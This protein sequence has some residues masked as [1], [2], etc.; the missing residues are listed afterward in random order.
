MATHI[1]ALFNDQNH[2]Q[3]ALR[4]LNERGLA[5]SR[6]SVI[7]ADKSGAAQEQ[8]VDSEGNL[9]AEGASKG[10]KSGLVVGG[11]AGAAIGVA[12]FGLGFVPLLGFLVAGPVAGLLTGAA[13]GAA[14][15]T[16]LGGLVGLG[17]PEH[18][19]ESYSESVRRGGY[20]VIADVDDANVDAYERILHDAGAVDVNESAGP[21]TSRPVTTGAATS[22]ATAPTGAATAASLA[23]QA[24]PVAPP[25][26]AP[27]MQPDTARTQTTETTQPAQTTATTTE[28]AEGGKIAIVEE[29]LQV[30]KREV[31]SGGVRVRRF[32]TEKEA[33]ADVQL[34]EEHVNVERHAVSRPADAA[35][36]KEGTIEVRTTAE[37]PVVAKEARVVEE[38]T[39]GKTA[40]TR[41]EHVSDTVRRSDVEIQQLEAEHRAH[42]EGNFAGKDYATYQPAY[43][44]GSRIAADSRYTGREYGTFESDLRA[45]Y[46][47]NNPTSKFD[48]AKAA[49]R[50]GYDAA[51]R[52]AQS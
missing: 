35:D 50:A 19:V 48:E 14:T 25:T 18:D 32:V 2:A 15:G 45:D 27:A 9:A 49:I 7:A 21:N 10:L 8:H 5:G 37:V 44:Y 1:V 33:T 24:R 13:A 6:I 29:E 41:T 17:I 39:I 3:T 12:S 31:E 40:E 36:F 30:G 38:V 26:P 43:Q 28:N 11:L 52:R 22:A 42:F 51:K 23:P 20:L 34:R 16:A 46:E 4:Q 47:R